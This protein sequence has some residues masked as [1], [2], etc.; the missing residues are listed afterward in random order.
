M[1]C[2]SV[3]WLR[4][5]CRNWEHT[6]LVVRVGVGTVVAGIAVAGTAVAGT[7][8]ADTAGAG[9]AVAGTLL[10]QAGTLPPSH[11][12]REVLAPYHS[13]VRN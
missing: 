11:R 13:K 12:T 4:Q 6:D 10:G 1:G 2:S 5:L 7:A 9:I 3:G 8:V